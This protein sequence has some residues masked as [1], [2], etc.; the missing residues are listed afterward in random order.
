MERILNFPA[1]I[2]DRI[3]RQLPPPWLEEDGSQ[4]ERLFE[5]L[6][7]RRRRLPQL[8]E[9]CRKAPGNPFPRWV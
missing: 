2:F 8:L 9:E 1:G 6:L 5:S 7:R 4:L 3:L